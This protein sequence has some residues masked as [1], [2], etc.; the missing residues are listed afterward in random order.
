MK[1]SLGWF[2]GRQ[3]AR[4]NNFEGQKWERWLVTKWIQVAKLA[5]RLAWSVRH[6]HSLELACRRGRTKVRSIAVEPAL[7]SDDDRLHNHPTSLSSHHNH[8]MQNQPT[9]FLSRLKVALSW[10]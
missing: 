7:A 3:Q 8:H 5:D 10:I 9:L 2:C 1:L 6:C 4:V